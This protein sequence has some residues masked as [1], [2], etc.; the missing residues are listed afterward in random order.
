MAFLNL[1][2]SA[3]ELANAFTPNGLSLELINQVR[4]FEEI[5]VDLVLFIVY[6]FFERLVKAFNRLID[7]QDWLKVIV[8]ILLSR[9]DN[10][11]DQFLPEIGM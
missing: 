11:I 8:L 6:D 3:A 9:R 2:L 4:N 7:V 1:A 5:N 10:Q